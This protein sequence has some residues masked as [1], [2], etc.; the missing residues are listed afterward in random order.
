M[1][2]K[3][4]LIVIAIMFIFPF[5]VKASIESEIKENKEVTIKSVPPKTEMQY[6]QVDEVFNSETGLNMDDCNSTYTVCNITKSNGT[7]VATDVEIIYD[8]D[9]DV[10][11]VVDDIL[12]K[13]PEGGISFTLNDIEMLY[14]LHDYAAYY[15]SDDN[16]DPEK[17]PNPLIYSHAYNSF[18]GYKNFVFEPRMGYDEQ[19]A[20]YKAGTASFKYNDTVYGFSDGISAYVPV[21]LFVEDD[22]TNVKDALQTRLEKYFPGI[23]INEDTT[24]SP[25]QEFQRQLD[26]RR[27][28]YRECKGYREI[29]NRIEPIAVDNRTEEERNEY[30]TASNN[31]NNMCPYYSYEELFEDEEAYMEDFEADLR[32]EEW[33]FVD[34]MVPAYYEVVFKDGVGVIVGVARDSDLVFNGEIKVV[35]SDSSSDVTISAG[36]VIPLDTLIQVAILTDGEEYERIVKV[37]E[38]VVDTDYVEMFDLKLFSKAANDYITKLDNGSFEVK[39]PISKAFEG[40]NLVVYYVD[41][42][43]ET[44]AYEVTIKD[45]Y[46]VFNTDHFSIYTLAV[47]EEENPEPSFKLTYD[48]NGG[49]RQ[50]EKEFVDESVGFGMDITETNFIDE[51]DVTPPEGKEL[52]AIEINGVRTELGDVYILNKDTVFKY[53]WKDATETSEETKTPEKETTTETASDAGEPVPKT[54]DN[55][56]SYIV[57]LI[58]SLLITVGSTK[59][60]LKKN[61]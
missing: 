26:E 30:E 39:I 27:D 9:E 10:K 23:V 29:I 50:G 38:K 57:L 37:L 20:I 8:Y 54:F 61:N 5:T 4:L 22:E 28:N 6:Y 11:E 46:A 40:E 33:R 21:L 42:K 34:D 55:I 44:V 3:Y 49:S 7:V 56:D 32:S 53:I 47:K 41:E 58:I 17:E 12:A 14:Y 43:G 31:W 59:Y 1:K 45:G 24:G 35:T 60:L 52:D 36:N 18:M 16:E 48:F 19:F 2:K 51:F 25:P 15:H 13:V